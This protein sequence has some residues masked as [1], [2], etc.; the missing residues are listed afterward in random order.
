MSSKS[1]NNSP[2]V[3]AVAQRLTNLLL[4]NS[5]DLVISSVSHQSRMLLIRIRELGSHYE[6]LFGSPFN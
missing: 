6:V 4:V 1:A 3:E 5:L 2:P